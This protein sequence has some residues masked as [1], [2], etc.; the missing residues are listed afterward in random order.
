MHVST[1]SLLFAAMLATVAAPAA[2]AGADHIHDHDDKSRKEAPRPR[3]RTNLPPS[4]EELMYN[5]PPSASRPDLA[6]PKKARKVQRSTATADC[7]DM[8]KLATY[9]GA[10][11]ADYVASLS[12]PACTY[13]LFSVPVSQ[14]NTIFAAANFNAVASRF[15]QEAS[16]YNASNMKLV[17][18]ALYLRAGY[19]QA[20]NSGVTAPPPSIVTSLRPSIKALVEGTQLYTHNAAA[21]TTAGEILRLITNMYDE[22]YYLPSMRGLV[23]RYTNSPSNPNAV[24]GIRNPTASGGFTGILTVINY[25]HSRPEGKALLQNDYS[26][27]SALINFVIYNKSALLGTSDAYQLSDAENEGLR[28]MQYDSLKPSIKPLTQYLLTYN[29][30]SGPDD[31]LWINAAMAVR[32]Y[33]ADRC[34]DYGTCGF[35]TKLANAVLVNNYTC[36]PTVKIRS[37]KLTQD[38]ANQAC[39]TMLAGESYFHNMLQ[40]NRTPVANDNNAALE[41]VVFD[42]TNNYRKYAGAIYDIDTDNGGMYLEG[43]PAVA[44]NQ[45]RF[46]AHRAAWL[47]DFQIW[48]LEHEYVHYLDGRFNMFGDFH[49]GTTKPTVWWI[50]GVAEYLSK[51]NNY[52]DAID[53]AKTAKYPLSTIFGNTYAMG[54]YQAR[55]YRWGYMA[56]RFMFERHRADVDA[57]L[58]K[59]RA[60]D[61]A[62][63]DAYMKNIGTRYDAEF[64]SWVQSA[65]TAGEPPMPVTTYPAC[66]SSSQL[67]K[68]CTIYNLGSGYRSYA[69]VL[70]PSGAKNLR[71]WTSGGT[72]D[73]DLYVAADRWPETTAYDA[74]SST[75]GNRESISI[76]TPMTGRWY[77]IMLNARQ[78]Y[79]GV[80]LSATWD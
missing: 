66:S 28:F 46:V 7:R 50:E 80:A 12:D 2:Y 59:F 68:N 69:Y 14:A 29:S 30:M 25:A 40:T 71:L 11:L 41:V 57:V 42:D 75:A 27:P 13:P 49:D 67:A 51:K 36:S 21:S 38:Q 64:A 1:R 70:L 60:G 26:Y 77:Y 23:L 44:G 62:G 6:D 43:D 61:Y 48:N 73:A 32:W 65:T 18:L 15:M 78:P 54:D 74:V 52:Q 55:A 19:Y 79:S 35:E 5:L 56:T 22:A 72:G 76:A 34:A 10:A 8:N 17:N 39:S 37:Q 63:Y 3:Q 47:P 58:A 4:L 45:A 9:S 53:V 24:Q 31:Q 16:A 20:N 33:D